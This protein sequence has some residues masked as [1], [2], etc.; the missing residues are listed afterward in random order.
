MK[1]G[2]ESALT[3][4]NSKSGRTVMSYPVEWRMILIFLDVDLE[5]NFGRSRRDFL[6]KNW[7]QN[8]A[9]AYLVSLR[10]CE[11]EWFIRNIKS[12]LPWRIARIAY[13][14]VTKRFW[15]TKCFNWCR[16]NQ[17]KAISK[18]QASKLDSDTCFRDPAILSSGD[19]RSPVLY[20]ITS[21]LLK[22]GAPSSRFP[23][24][25]PAL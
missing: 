22:N 16:P 5:L 17:W 7:L 1:L 2:N 9:S 6:S 19:L 13:F 20:L 14:V 8:N 21:L 12:R 24:V 15:M 10:H 11:R 25:Q 18:F 3:Y 4:R 23:V